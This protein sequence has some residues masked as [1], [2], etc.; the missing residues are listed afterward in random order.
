M[1]GERGEPLRF[2]HGETGH[3]VRL[4]PVGDGVWEVTAAGRT[5]RVRVLR[6]TEAGLHLEVGGRTLEAHVAVAA[7][8]V[9]VHALGRSWGLER[10]AA[11]RPARS[12]STAQA[13]DGPVR[14]VMPGTV[15]RVLVAAGERVEAGQ[16]LVILEAMKMEHRLGAPYAGEVARVAVREGQ[17][18][19]MR[20]PLVELRRPS[21]PDPA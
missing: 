21:G 11:E 4:A 16:V 19:A 1:R 13:E 10:L 8:T 17:Q 7:G 15:A 3:E 6:S 2:R 5:E 18:V 12:G 14:A 20:E 9:H